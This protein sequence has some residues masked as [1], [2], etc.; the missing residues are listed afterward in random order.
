METNSDQLFMGSV[1]PEWFGEKE[2]EIR[3]DPPAM[4]GVRRILR[5]GIAPSMRMFLAEC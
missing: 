3:E 2:E 4:Q 1:V 5:D